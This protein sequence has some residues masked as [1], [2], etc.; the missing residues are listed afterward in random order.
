MS[1]TARRLASSWTTTKLI[2][3]WWTPVD[4]ATLRP[5]ATTGECSAVADPFQS[6]V[7]EPR[8]GFLTV[9]SRCRD[10][11][12]PAADPNAPRCVEVA[13][14]KL[15][16]NELRGTIEFGD[17]AAG[18]YSLRFAYYD[19]PPFSMKAV[20]HPRDISEMDAEIRYVTFFGTV[21]QGV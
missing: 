17:V 9:L 2:V 11:R 21:T 14:R 3:H 20:A 6:P 12:K 15:P 18:E 5:K 13:Q 19:L 16:E 1:P 10:P 4:L 8:E 7:S